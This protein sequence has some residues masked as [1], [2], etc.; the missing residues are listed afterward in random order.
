[1]L[2]KFRGLL[3]GKTLYFAGLTWNFIL[4]KECLAEHI[5]ISCTQDSLVHKQK[6]V[7]NPKVYNTMN[8]EE[9]T[10]KIAIAALQSKILK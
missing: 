8:F 1:M 7:V 3:K 10:K 2:K 9:K 4:Q 6:M 5:R